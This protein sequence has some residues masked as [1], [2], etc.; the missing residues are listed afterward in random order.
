[1]YE[2]L[3]VDDDG[4]KFYEGAAGWVAPKLIAVRVGDTVYITE[5]I[6]QAKS[7]LVDPPQKATRGMKRKR[8]NVASMQYNGRDA[9]KQK[10]ASHDESEKDEE[11]CDADDNTLVDR[12][13]EVVKETVTDPLELPKEKTYVDAT[14]FGTVEAV[15]HAKTSSSITVVFLTSVQEG[16]DEEKLFTREKFGTRTRPKGL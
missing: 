14:F 16:K 2:C 9:R 15:T 4:P 6:L 1:M 5:K 8:G 11:V 10:G 3:S 7:L 12:A 13:K